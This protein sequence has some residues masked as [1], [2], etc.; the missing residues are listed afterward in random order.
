[1]IFLIL[2]SI[3]IAVTSYFYFFKKGLQTDK[4]V[5]AKQFDVFLVIDHSGS[6][7]GERWTPFHL[8]LKACE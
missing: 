8:T 1:M 2:I 7:K 3:G 5:D 4:T 6:M